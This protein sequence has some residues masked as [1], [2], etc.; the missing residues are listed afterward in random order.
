VF[1]AESLGFDTGIDLD[2]LIKAREIVQQ[3]LPNEAL[4]GQMAKAGL[5]KGFSYAEGRKAA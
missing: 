2:R 5:P 3:A 1:L 4:Y